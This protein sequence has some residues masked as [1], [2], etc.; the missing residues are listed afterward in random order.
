MFQPG[1]P[2]SHS[3]RVLIPPRRPK[4]DE[5]R[6]TSETQKFP[7]FDIE[8]FRPVTEFLPQFDINKLYMTEAVGPDGST[9]RAPTKKELPVPSPPS[10]PSYPHTSGRS[11][12]WQLN[13]NF[14]LRDHSL[15]LTTSTK[16]NLTLHFVTL[17]SSSLSCPAEGCR[18]ILDPGPCRDYVVKWYYDETSNACA[19]F[20]F[21]GCLGNKNQFETEEKCHE[22]CVKFY[23]AFITNTH[24]N[25]WKLIKLFLFSWLCHKMSSFCDQGS[26]GN[27]KN[28]KLQDV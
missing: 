1:S 15:D 14:H 17:N 16:I 13:Y 7:F 4:P 26:P 27:N 22:T 12:F 11:S 20:W 5:D 2:A 18:Q 10:M 8:P 25:E 6:T 24:P 23:W 9:Q 3:D 28:T 21:G 19:Q